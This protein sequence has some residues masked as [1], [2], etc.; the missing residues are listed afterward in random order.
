M[1]KRFEQAMTAA[2]YLAYMLFPKYST[3]KLSPEQLNEGQTMLISINPQLVPDLLKFTARTGIP[4]A[5]SL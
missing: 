1:Q 4:K 2:H 3:D 5:L